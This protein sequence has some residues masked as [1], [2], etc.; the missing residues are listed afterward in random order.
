MKLSQL[1][2][3]ASTLVVIFQFHTVSASGGGTSANSPR[4]D[5]SVISMTPPTSS[6]YQFRIIPFSHYM[7]SAKLPPDLVVTFDIACYQTFIK[8]IRED[9]VDSATG[10]YTIVIGALVSENLYLP[11]SSMESRTELAGPTFSGR[12]YEVKTIAQ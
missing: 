6:Y 5:S 8:V 2:L 4:R 12:E 3:L 1:F 9:I 11:C 10:K 7:E